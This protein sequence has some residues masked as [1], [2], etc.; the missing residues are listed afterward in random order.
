MVTAEQKMVKKEKQMTLEHIFELVCQ[1][2]ATSAG[3]PRYKCHIEDLRLCSV[4]CCICAKQ[5]DWDQIQPI[6]INKS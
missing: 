2:A 5:T 6:I 4:D 3:F 1:R